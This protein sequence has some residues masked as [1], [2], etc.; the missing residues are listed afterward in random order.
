MTR[1]ESFNNYFK[2]FCN[3]FQNVI[4]LRNDMVFY[5]KK[6]EVLF[7]DLSRHFRL[8]PRIQGMTFSLLIIYL[9]R[10]LKD[11]ESHSIYKL[12]RKHSEISGKGKGTKD[13]ELLLVKLKNLQNDRMYYVINTLRNKYYAHLALDRSDFEVSLSIEIL[14][15]YIDDIVGLFKDF[16][17]VVKPGV[18]IDLAGQ[19]HDVDMYMYEALESYIRYEENKVK[20]R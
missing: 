18:S 3:N 2:S 1:E 10:I 8:I 16:Y 14:D 9:Y 11:S 13:H 20:T 19:S 17:L 5:A 7:A 12:I 6:S 15:N 4:L